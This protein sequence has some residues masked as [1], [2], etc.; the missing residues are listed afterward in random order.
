MNP[1]RKNIETRVAVIGG[2]SFCALLVAVLVVISY[3]FTDS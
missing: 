3:S 2:L 1:K